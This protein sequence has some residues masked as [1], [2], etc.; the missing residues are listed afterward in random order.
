M[1]LQGYESSIPPHVFFA[2]QAFPVKNRVQ[3]KITSVMNDF[4]DA[5]TGESDSRVVDRLKIRTVSFGQAHW[6]YNDITP[7]PTV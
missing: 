1:N 6:F 2:P 4:L 5:R 7:V 3:E